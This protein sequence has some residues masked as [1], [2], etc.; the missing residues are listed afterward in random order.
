MAKQRGP[1]KIEGTLD[2]I[3]FIK[4][5]DGYVAK[6][7]GGVAS[8]K[9]KSDP[10]FALTRQNNAEFTTAAKGGK[11]IREAFATVIKGAA[12]GRMISRLVKE[13]MKVVKSDTTSARGQRTVDKGNLGFLEGFEF[14]GNAPLKTTLQAPFTTNI[15]RASGNLI[16]HVPTFIPGNMLE[17]PQGSTHFRFVVMG[18][19]VDFGNNVYTSDLGV[20]ASLP[21]DYNP[22]ANIALNAVVPANATQDLFLLFGVQFFQRVNGLDYAM[23]NGKFNALQIASISAA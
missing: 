4:T 8:S 21:I 12:D 7:K 10:S 14:N 2:E 3:N 20:T 15:D 19:E 22:T 11:L 5:I 1:L 23:N 16:V 18:G 17:R 6:M 13:A 9:I